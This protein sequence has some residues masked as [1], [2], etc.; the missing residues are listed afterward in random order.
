MIAVVLGICKLGGLVGSCGGFLDWENWG[1]LPYGIGLNGKEIR[2]KSFLI[3][4]RL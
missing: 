2:R 3:G 1:R 4:I